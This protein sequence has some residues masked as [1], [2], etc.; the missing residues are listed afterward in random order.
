MCEDFHLHNV[1]IASVEKILKD[2]GVLKPSKID[3]VSAK[4]LKNGAPVIAIYM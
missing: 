4:F 1:E 2:L 3:Q